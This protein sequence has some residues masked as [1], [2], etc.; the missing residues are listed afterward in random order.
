[1]YV[2]FIFDKFWFCWSKIFEKI[3]RN[4]FL[5]KPTKKLSSLVCAIMAVAARITKS[6]NLQKMLSS[7]KNTHRCECIIIVSKMQSETSAKYFLQD[8][9]LHL[10]HHHITWCSNWYQAICQF[11]KIFLIENFS[12]RLYVFC[13]LI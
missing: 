12:C 2:K 13:N 10:I 7:A 4:Y 9:S 8:D 11:C 1:M 5:S 6:N 3:A